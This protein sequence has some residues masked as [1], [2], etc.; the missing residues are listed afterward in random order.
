MTLPTQLHPLPNQLYAASKEETG[1][2]KIIL[3]YRHPDIAGW[4]ALIRINLT[5]MRIEYKEFCCFSESDTRFCKY[6]SLED[7]FRIVREF[8]KET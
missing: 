3:A 6:A 7:A 5:A 1:E 4:Y 8:A 2:D